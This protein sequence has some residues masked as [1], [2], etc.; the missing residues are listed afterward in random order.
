MKILELIKIIREQ[1]FVYRLDTEALTFMVKK[2]VI[3]AGMLCFVQ[4]PQNRQNTY[5]VSKSI[6]FTKKF[7]YKIK[8]ANK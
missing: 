5:T 4:P 7:S 2:E 1:N 8:K 6:S 3:K